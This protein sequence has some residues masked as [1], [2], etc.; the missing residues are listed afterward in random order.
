MGINQVDKL[1]SLYKE[2]IST[3]RSVNIKNEHIKSK[4]LIKQKEFANGCERLSDK[5]RLLLEEE[6]KKYGKII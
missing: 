6:I 5:D 1:F 4:W 2:L 3:L